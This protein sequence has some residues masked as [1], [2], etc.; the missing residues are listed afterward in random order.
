LSNDD[1]IELEGTV[2]DSFRGGR[3]SV[4]LES[5]NLVNCV[6]SG[7]MRKNYIKILNGDSVTVALSPYDLTTG[8]ITW[9]H[10]PKKHKLSD[11]TTDNIGSVDN[12]E[13]E[14]LT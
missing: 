11:E 7:R 9:R 8:R 13:N 12:V 3:F 2:V 1:N 10:A 5:G 4:E 14:Q 6:L